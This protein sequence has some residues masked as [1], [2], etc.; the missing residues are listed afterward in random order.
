MLQATNQW[1]HP[2]DVIA[3]ASGVQYAAIVHDNSQTV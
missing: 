3:N 1:Q 2:H